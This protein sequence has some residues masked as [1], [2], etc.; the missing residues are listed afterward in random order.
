MERLLRTPVLGPVKFGHM[1][2]TAL[3][4]LPGAQ[5]FG[6]LAQN[7]P[8]FRIRYCR[9]DRRNHRCCDLVLYGEHLRVT[10]IIAFRPNMA[11]CFGIDKLSINAHLLRI[12]P[13]ATFYYVTNASRA[14]CFVATACP[15]Y[16]KLELRAMTNS[17]R[18]RESSVMMS[19][20]MP[21]EKYS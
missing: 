2:E 4:C 3:I 1:P 11:S 5:V 9:F 13:Y 8:K 12:A 10:T 14:T 20:E 15:L 7:A 19:S 17:A 16:V 21:S 6:T 18:L